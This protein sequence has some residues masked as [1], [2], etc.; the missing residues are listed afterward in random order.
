LGLSPIITTASS[1]HEEFLKSL[2][3]THVVDRN[4]PAA[5]LRDEIEKIASAPIKHVFDAISSQETQQFGHDLLVP[6]GQLNIVVR[7]KIT[8]ADDK[9]ILYVMGIRSIP[10]H[11]EL[12]E[13]MYSKLTGFLEDGVIVVCS[14]FSRVNDFR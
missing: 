5:L 6:G 12:L 7:Q 2:G 1:K 11:R 8:K 3:A 10:E 9:T 4:N 14:V 13:I